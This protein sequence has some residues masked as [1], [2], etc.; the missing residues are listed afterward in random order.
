MDKPSC[1]VKFRL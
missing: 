1:W